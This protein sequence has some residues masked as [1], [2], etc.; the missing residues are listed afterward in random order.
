MT[1]E[2]PN[3]KKYERLIA[4]MMRD[5]LDTNFSVT[6][7]ATIKGISSNINRQIDVLIDS[8]H[9]TDNSTRLIVDAKIRTRKISLLDVESFIGLMNDVQATHGYLVSTNGFTKSAIIRAQEAI[10][11]RILPLE[12]LENFEP[13]NWPDCTVKNCKNGKVFWDGYPAIDLYVQPQGAINH[14]ISK[15]T[16]VNYVGKCDK[17]RCFYIKCTNC[18]TILMVPHSDSGD[19]GHQCTCRPSWFWLGSIESDSSGNKSAELHLIASNKVMTV[20]HRSF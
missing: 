19:C 10:T 13:S 20:S 18:K 16:I 2:Y 11:L 15:L 6:P 17:C 12:Y 7:N 8:R 9:D 14:E 4:Q 5:Q 3:W 1:S